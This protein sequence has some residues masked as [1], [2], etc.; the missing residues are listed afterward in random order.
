[1]PSQSRPIPLIWSTPA[2]PA[3]RALSRR[4]IVTAAIEVAD[5]HGAAALT[6]AAVAGR[7]GDYTSMSLYR[8][9]QS[10]EGLIDLMLD[11]AIS[12]V[13]LPDPAPG[14]R[15]ALRQLGLDSWEMAHR[16]LWYA[17]LVHTRPPL[18]PNTMRR[19]EAVLRLLVDAGADVPRALSYLALLDRHVF[20]AAVVDAEE[21]RMAHTYGIDNAADLIAAIREIHRSVTDPG[22][23]P[24]L[25]GWMAAPAGPTTEE[26]V[27]QALDFILDG[28]QRQLRP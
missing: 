13:P 2:P 24:L 18:G 8:Y 9:V 3:R 23:Y 6:M 27:V 5:A 1:M 7:L 19:T 25:S 20:S 10:K 14:W 26:Q 22:A 15:A 11:A 28:M 12:E 17:Q 4:S 21:R 16:H